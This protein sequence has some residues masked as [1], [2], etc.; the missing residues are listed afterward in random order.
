M[1]SFT[2]VLQMDYQMG[3]SGLAKGSCLIPGVDKG[4]L[5][6]I[7]PESKISALQGLK[8]FHLISILTHQCDF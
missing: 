1:H 8:L 3:Q 7:Q 4:F 5:H 6:E 2:E